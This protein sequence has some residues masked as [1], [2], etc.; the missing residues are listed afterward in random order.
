MVNLTQYEC[1]YIVEVPRKL[2]YLIL[3][4]PMWKVYGKSNTEGVTIHCVSAQKAI[5]LDI[6]TSY[7]EG[8][9]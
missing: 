2:F 7:V 6:D 3:I 9:W 4:L 1:P 5:L 8:L